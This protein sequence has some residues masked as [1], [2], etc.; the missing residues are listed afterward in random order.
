MLI[1]GPDEFAHRVGT[2]HI[3]AHAWVTHP[4]S[5]MSGTLTSGAQSPALDVGQATVQGMHLRLDH[6]RPTAIFCIT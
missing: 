6:E 5:I 1:P 2:E 3:V 4:Y